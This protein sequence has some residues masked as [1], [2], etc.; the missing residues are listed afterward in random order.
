M[1]NG[2]SNKGNNAVTEIETASVIHQ[3]IIHTAVAI[4]VSAFSEM[5]STGNN[6]SSENR[7]GPKNSPKR[8][9]NG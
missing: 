2:K 9:D 6:E 7:M 1:N 3:M 8:L 4:T 5:N